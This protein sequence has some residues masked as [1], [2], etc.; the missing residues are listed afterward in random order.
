MSKI[1]YSIGLIIN[2]REQKFYANFDVE[3]KSSQE[4]KFQGTKVL[5]DEC[6]KERK[7]YLWNFRSREWKFS[8]TKVPVTVNVGIHVQSVL[9]RW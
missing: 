1:V 8:G 9:N 5:G 7:F 6:S 3:N 4:R 2:V